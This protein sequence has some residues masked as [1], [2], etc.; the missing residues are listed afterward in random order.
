MMNSS[1]NILEGQFSE[2][3]NPILDIEAKPSV[4]DEKGLRLVEEHPNEERKGVLKLDSPEPDFG[5]HLITDGIDDL[6]PSSPVDSPPVLSPSDTDDSDPEWKWR[7]CYGDEIDCQKL[8]VKWETKLLRRR[9]RL[10]PELYFD[11]DLFESEVESRL[12]N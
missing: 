5:W 4:V 9:T 10:W 12:L 2:P 6:S 8:L 1:K 7:K 11:N 3:L